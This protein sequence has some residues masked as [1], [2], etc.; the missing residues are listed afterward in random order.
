MECVETALRLATAGKHYT[1]TSRPG[2][3]RWNWNYG[4]PVQLQLES[5]RKYSFAGDTP[6]IRERWRNTLAFPFYLPV[7]YQQLPLGAAS[8]RNSLRY[9]TCRSQVPFLDPPFCSLW[10][11]SPM[12]DLSSGREQGNLLRASK[13]RI[14]KVGVGGGEREKGKRIELERPVYQPSKLRD[15]WARETAGSWWAL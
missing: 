3:D 14:S 11:S 5:Q 9:T 7:F 12:T 4:G 10:P 13:P 15:V 6:W 2:T 8:W 1:M